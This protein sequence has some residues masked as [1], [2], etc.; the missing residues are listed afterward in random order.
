MNYSYPTTGRLDVV[1]ALRGFAIASIL[2]LHNL[3]HFDFAFFPDYLPDWLKTIDSY[4]WDTM[5]FLFGGK[6]YS[7]FA[8]LFG[9]TFFIQD[10]HQAA[11]GN[12]FR[13]RFAWRLL[14]LLGFSAVNS[15][16]YQGD[17]L[18]FFAVFGLLLIPVCRLSDRWVFAIMLFLLLQPYELGSLI[19]L[20]VN[21]DATYHMT[22]C[23][24]WFARTGEFFAGNS[25]PAMMKC[26]LTYGKWTVILWNLENGRFFQI[27]ALFMAGML[28]GRRGL[29]VA[30]EESL[31]FWK[32]AVL[33]GFVAF[34]LCYLL[35]N[36]G[37][38][39]FARPE[40][41]RI[42]VK[43]FGFWS[44]LGLT[45]VLI[46]LF[47]SLY[48]NESWR[49]TLNVFTPLGKMSLTNYV[50]SSVFGFFVY[51]GCGLGLYR[52]TGATMSFIIGL[53]LVI[54]LWWFCTLY[55]K[56]HKHGPLEHIWHKLTWI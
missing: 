7:I 16:F 45:V 55:G 2:V 22:N 6:S 17:I 15:V 27:P 48:Q 1:D 5:F 26:N 23:G 25:V 42:A 3:E 41:N 21:P 36:C 39:F 18:T 12:D 38:E 32:K 8:L 53:I 13:G 54:G 28:I 35:K 14:L 33:W 50:L 37:A 24:A 20:G 46:G 10:S 31:K 49:K 11:K 56:N 30:S 43:L 34:A 29:F 9:F 51:Y 47:F 40:M 19:A 52:Y 44:N 4:F